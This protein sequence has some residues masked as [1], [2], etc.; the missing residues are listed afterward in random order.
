VNELVELD[1]EECYRYLASVPVGRIA[2]V[3]GGVPEVVPV[4]FAVLDEDVVVRT[5]TG[6]LL[7]A[8]RGSSL[9]AFEVDGWDDETRT[10]WSVLVQGP[11]TEVVRRDQLA[12]LATLA[13]RSWAPGARGHVLRL[14]TT[15][16]SGRRLV[17]GGDV[18][19][20]DAY[21]MCGPDHAVSRLPL[22]PLPPV[23]ADAT[24][25][26]ALRLLHAARSPIGSLDPRTS[27]FIGTTGLVRALVAGASEYTP[28]H[29]AVGDDVLVLPAFTGLLD[30]LRTMSTRDVSHAVV[31]MHYGD[32]FGL[33][34]VGDVVSPLL[35]VF[36]PIVVQ[37][38]ARRDIQPDPDATRPT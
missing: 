14:R 23:P 7:G 8:A 29:V 36:D 17:P 10:G 13:I 6:L 35:W 15:V 37:L 21:D 20:P 38:R 27:R 26:E 12:L 30:A 24:I 19:L 4:N 32:R 2:V 34:T 31:Q 25:A 28:A 9:A 3:I 33:L 5:G 11:L 1:R 18:R 16:I 22:R